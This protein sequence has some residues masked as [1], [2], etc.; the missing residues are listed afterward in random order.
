MHV[1]CEIQYT[2]EIE[3]GCKLPTK[4]LITGVNDMDVTVS[5]TMEILCSLW[6][7]EYVY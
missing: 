5:N 3:V 4:L 7:E 1:L 2:L 6:D